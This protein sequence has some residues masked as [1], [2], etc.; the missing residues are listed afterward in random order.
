MKLVALFLVLVPV[1]AASGP[2]NG[3]GGGARGP[4]C[5]PGLLYTQAQCCRNLLNIE[6]L[7]CKPA[8]RSY[9]GHDDF[10]AACAAEGRAA[11]CCTIPVAGLG[12]LCNDI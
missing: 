6:Y 3:N 12:L 4:V 8:P 2:S 5:S 9:N 10:K 7:D 1:L 11:K